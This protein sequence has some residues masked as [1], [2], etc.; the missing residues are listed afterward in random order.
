MIL[1][2][3]SANSVKFRAVSEGG[4]STLGYSHPDADSFIIHVGRPDGSTLDIPLKA[5]SLW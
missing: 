1:E 4:M 5:R 3:I 2:E